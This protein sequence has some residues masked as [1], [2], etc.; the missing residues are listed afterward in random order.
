MHPSKGPRAKG[1]IYIAECSSCW[2]QTSL[3][4][5]YSQKCGCVQSE[6][7]DR[8]PS[9]K[10]KVLSLLFTEIAQLTEHWMFSPKVGGANPSLR[11]KNQGGVMTPTK[12]GLI[13]K[14]C[15]SLISNKCVNSNLASP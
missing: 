12:R 11:T 13:L 5:G 10:T 6:K 7:F 14:I 2:T 1:V 4:E 3:Y 9:Q 8:I 15:K